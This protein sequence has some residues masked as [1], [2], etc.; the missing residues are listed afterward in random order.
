MNQVHL[1]FLKNAIPS[2]SISILFPP[3][4]SLL[5][6]KMVLNCYYYLENKLPK[7]EPIQCQSPRIYQ[8]IPISLFL[9]AVLC[10]TDFVLMLL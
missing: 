2:F 1:S 10:Y 9:I 6:R 8:Q 7:L 5:G 3:Q 4:H